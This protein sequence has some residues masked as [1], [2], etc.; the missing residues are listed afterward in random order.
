VILQ[1]KASPVVRSAARSLLASRDAHAPSRFRRLPA[2]QLTA[3]VR[4]RPVA[5]AVLPSFS[6]PPSSS[7]PGLH[8]P[9]ERPDIAYSS[10]PQYREPPRLRVNRPCV[11][12]SPLLQ[13]W[14]PSV[15]GASPT[16]DKQALCRKLP[17]SV[18]LAFL[19]T[20]NTPPL[21]GWPSSG[22]GDSPPRTHRPVAGKSS[23]D[24]PPPNQAVQLTPLARPSPGRD[25]L[26]KAR[27]PVGRFANGLSHLSATSSSTGVS[28]LAGG[29][30]HFAS[31][32]LCPRPAR[33]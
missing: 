15:Q 25:L 4:R 3:R 22:Q 24:P 6:P 10:L 1:P 2:A 17:T 28:R 21:L 29:G 14:P 13:P 27:P 20:A 8:P 30:S 12:N 11:G 33:P 16:T 26:G 32:S 9:L 18:T 19:R 7:E 31:A 23:R 5:P